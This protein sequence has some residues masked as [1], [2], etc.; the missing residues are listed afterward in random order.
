MT[1][2]LDDRINDAIAQS[3]PGDCGTASFRICVDDPFFHSIHA[4]M[5]ERGYT[6]V[7]VSPGVLEAEVEFTWHTNPTDAVLARQAEWD[8]LGA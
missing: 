5:I 8:A 2:S 1:S 3:G 7:Y 6:G 4:E